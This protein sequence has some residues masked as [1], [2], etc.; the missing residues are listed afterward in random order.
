[1]Q[2][3]NWG[4]AAAGRIT[5]DFVT[6][7][8][9]IDEHS[10]HVVNAVADVDVQR[11]KDFAE[12]HN[13][14]KYYDGFDALSLDPEV[15]IVYVGTLNPFHYTVVRLMLERGKNVLCEKPI[16]LCYEQAAEL[17]RL[18]KERKVFL[19]EGMWSRFFPSY[20]RLRELLLAG[21]IGEVSHIQVQHGFR[22]QEVERIWTRSLGG[23]IT[24]DVGL[25]ALQLGQFVFD[26]APVNVKAS[27]VLNTD[28]VDVE[29]E[30][31]LDYGQN[32]K[33]AAFVTGRENI[34]CCA[35][36]LGTKGEIKVSF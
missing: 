25:Y 6:A 10:R 19:M 15:D 33:L 34:E 12:R 29:S 26:C 16:C 2:N 24:L 14:A 31:V 5:H 27:G 30:F 20:L 22:A 13:I 18:A 7:L 17:Y 36:I 32:R 21:C 35:K 23:S 11:A 28:G 8:S 3:L 9:T 1:M 4:I